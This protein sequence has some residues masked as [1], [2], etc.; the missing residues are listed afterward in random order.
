MNDM[1]RW[2]MLVEA[3]TMPT[4]LFHGT[5][6][7][8]LHQVETGGNKVRRVYHEANV[9]LGGTYLTEHLSIAKVAAMNA[10]REHHS[11]PIIL[12]VRI[13]HP[14]FPDEDWVVPA[15]ERP[16]P[17]DFNWKT[18]TYKSKRYRDFFAD[19]FS[20]YLGEGHSLSDEYA[21]RYTELNRH[22]ITWKDSLRYTGSVRQEHPLTP[23]QIEA[24]EELK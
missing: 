3:E 9:S 17:Q 18:E 24:V 4:T 7:Y 2:M 12:T 21:R 15:T 10:A 8:V 5:S 13:I 20:E 16:K 14:L 11:V 22:G 19:L 23:D 1:R 6:A